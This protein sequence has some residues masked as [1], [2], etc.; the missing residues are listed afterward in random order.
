MIP[1]FPVQFTPTSPVVDG[2][3]ILTTIGRNLIQAIWNRTGQA[4]G[5]PDQVA[6]NLK[7]T[8]TTQATALQL[9]DDWNEILSVPAGSGV[10]LMELQ[11]GQEQRVFNGDPAQALKVWPAVGYQI[12][13]LGLNQPYSLAHGKTQ[14]FDAYSTTQ[15]RSVQLG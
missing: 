10:I 5:I 4:S 3:G 15:I 7:A 11:P 13:A 12:D 14:L 2:G 8:G 9:N 6:N 1:Q